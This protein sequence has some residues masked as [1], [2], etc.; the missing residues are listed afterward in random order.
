MILE[1]HTEEKAKSFGQVGGLT[2]SQMR[3]DGSLVGGPAC[4]AQAFTSLQAPPH[5]PGQEEARPTE[6]LLAGFWEG[7]RPADPEGGYIHQVGGMETGCCPQG[8]RGSKVQS[9]TEQG[10]RTEHFPGLPSSFEG[11][12]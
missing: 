10:L 3:G 7:R 4:L 8:P 12:P 9:D 11:F 2:V 6:V 5:P 1:I